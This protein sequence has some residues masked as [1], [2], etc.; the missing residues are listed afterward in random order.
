MVAFL[1]S[2]L[3]LAL[4]TSA[5]ADEFAQATG[6][7]LE[8]YCI[9]CHGEKKQKGGIRFDDLVSIEDAFIK[10]GQLDSIIDQVRMG[11]MPPDDED[12]LPT[13]GERKQ[14]IAALTK[15]SDRV[16]SGDVPQRAGRVTLRRLNRNEY[17]YTVRDLYGVKFDP[18]RGFPADGAGGEGFDNTA[19]ALFSTP[20]LLEKYLGAA[21]KVVAAV[22]QDPQLKGKVI[23]K[24]PG[25]PEQALAMAKEV[26]GYHATLAYRRRVSAEDLDPLMNS[27]AKGIQAG[28]SFDEAMRGPL[29]AILLN[30]RFLFRAEHDEEGRDEWK[31]N[32]FEIATRLSYFL[33]SSMPDRE[34]FRLADEGKLSDP[35]VLKS[36]TLRM[37][38]SPK[39]DALAKHFAGQWIGFDKMIDEVQ[40]DTERFPTF[41][42]NLRKAMYFEGIE[43]FNYIL[44]ENRPIGELIDSDYTFAN[45]TLARHYGLKEKVEGERLRKVTLHDKNRG[46]VLGMGSVLASTSLPLR[47]SP[48]KRGV[49]ILDS[50]LGDPPPPPPPDAGELPGDDANSE[51]LTFREQLDVHRRDPNCANCHSRIDPL[52][53]SLENYDAIGR[54]REKDTNGLALDTTALLPGDIEFSSPQE[55]KMLLMAGQEKFARNMIRK[56]LSYATGRGLEYYDEATLTRIL[57]ELEKSDYAMHDLIHQI[58]RSRPFLYRSSTR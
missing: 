36:Q 53:F 4:V 41:N 17:H 22:Y 34:L 2:G 14:L 40:P 11:D 49:F 25:K 58:V 46:G 27:F 28:Q 30:P 7:I 18:S 1:R 32:D 8:K 31:L 55:L 51:N 37:I 48:V 23:F 24:R 35:A 33:W 16:A 45:A 5:W 13:D 54:W 47:T 56:M 50:L 29:T 9:S 52:G 42:A 19:D 39:S 20:T 10:H 21:K 57:A 3:V 43:F 44:R 6:P 26:L 12:L 15:V 38:Q